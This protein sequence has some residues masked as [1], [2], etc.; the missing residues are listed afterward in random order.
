MIYQN[1]THK[2]FLIYTSNTHAT[3]IRNMSNWLYVNKIL[4]FEAFNYYYDVLRF[5]I[6]LLNYNKIKIFNETIYDGKKSLYLNYKEN[7]QPLT[8][9]THLYMKYDSKFSQNEITTTSLDL[10]IDKKLDIDFVK[11]DI[12]GCEYF[13]LSGMM[14]IINKNKPVIIFEFFEPFLDRYDLSKNDLINFFTKNNY[15]IFQFNNNSLE[16]IDN[17]IGKKNNHN[18][19]AINKESSFFV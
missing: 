18:F 17:L 2:K 7:N 10:F 4:C 19:I 11:I 14:S 12:E 15:S 13:A 6:F 5:K 9:M 3:T 1:M 16:R 8:G